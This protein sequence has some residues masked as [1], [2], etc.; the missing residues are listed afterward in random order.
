MTQ[1]ARSNARITTNDLKRLLALAKADQ[2]SFLDRYPRWARL[3]AD[4]RI[5]I[6]L[7]QGAAQHFVGQGTGVKD[8]D[9]WVFYRAHPKAPFP[10]RRI[11][12][13]D[14]G[15]PKFGRAPG[16]PTFRGRCVDVIGRSIPSPAGSDS[17]TA[18][19]DYLSSGKTDSARELAKKAVV[20]LE[21]RLG[22]IVWP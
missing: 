14:F 9:V 5:G 16:R 20:M 15:D 17:I 6:A 13:Q 1:T 2:A 7:C 8:F 18:I 4:R 11:G 10:Y 12:R 3:Y 21:P 22:A 19:R